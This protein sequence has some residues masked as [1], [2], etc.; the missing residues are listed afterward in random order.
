MK[1]IVGL[2]N[3]GEKY[4]QNRHNVG[5]MF[6]NYLLEIFKIKFESRSMTSQSPSFKADK[7]LFSEIAQIGASN[8][9]SQQYILAKPQTY[10]NKS[11]D[12]VKKT[13]LHYKLKPSQSLIVIHDDLDISFGK[14]KIQMQGPKVHNGIT[15]IQNKLQTMDFLRVRIGVDNRPSENRMGGEEYVLQNFIADELA[16]LPELFKKIEVRL[17]AFLQAN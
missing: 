11:G 15:D 14:F 12:A 9:Q 3:P 2:G 7:Y 16:Q 5:F 10:M 13:V 17:E 8:S 6:L 4:K 1:L